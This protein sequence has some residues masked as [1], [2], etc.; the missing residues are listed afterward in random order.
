MTGYSALRNFIR[1]LPDSSSLRQASSGARGSKAAEASRFV[2]L[3][4]RII[5]SPK[6]T[7]ISPIN[8]QNYE[9]MKRDPIQSSNTME[10]LQPN[11]T[12][13]YVKYVEPRWRTPKYKKGQK[14]WK[15]AWPNIHN[16]CFLDRKSPLLRCP[17]FLKLI[18]S[19]GT[20]LVVPW[21]GLRASTAAG[22]GLI[23][24]QGPKILHSKWCGQKKKKKNL[25]CNLLLIS[26][27]GNLWKSDSFIWQDYFYVCPNEK[28]V[29]E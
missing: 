9:I 25:Q 8:K 15:K 24:C 4:D 22:K 18:C 14:G 2:I 10:N 21:L 12:R 23:P 13:E 29:R 26:Q 11:K 20:S 28:N 16:L 5:L 7:I 19:T 1:T 27:K 3:V 6:V 17:F